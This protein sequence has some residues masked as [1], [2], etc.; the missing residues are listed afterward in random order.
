ME[1]AAAGLA[2]GRLATL[3]LKLTPLEAVALQARFEAELVRV[4]LPED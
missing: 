4:D 1:P 3:S 2:A